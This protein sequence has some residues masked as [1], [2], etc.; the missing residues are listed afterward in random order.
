[1]TTPAKA[2]DTDPLLDAVAVAWTETFTPIVQRD[3]EKWV[4][5][6]CGKF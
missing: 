4:G 1:M 6:R 2:K 5:E 3:L